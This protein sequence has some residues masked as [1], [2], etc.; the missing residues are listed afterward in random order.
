MFDR[1]TAIST[2]DCSG[3]PMKTR[4]LIISAI[5]VACGAII[6][7]SRRTVGATEDAPPGHRVVTIQSGGLSRSF[8]LHLPPACDGN[9][10][11]PLVL[12]L[13]GMGGTAA[14]SARET[15]WS[16]M[17]QNSNWVV[18]GLL[19]EYGGL[20]R[21]KRPTAGSRDAVGSRT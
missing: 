7:V 6:A 3:V 9:K 20:Y 11:L 14:N 19:V 13:H 21:R 16:G 4:I 8:L 10:P 12:M 17:P 2:S 15:G 1:E 18:R 5:V